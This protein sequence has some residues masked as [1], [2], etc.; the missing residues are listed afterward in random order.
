MGD[1][2]IQPPIIMVK[3][4]NVSSIRG[5]STVPQD[6]QIFDFMSSTINRKLANKKG[7]K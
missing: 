2:Q 6:K 5:L 3:P 4:I 1:L 7:I